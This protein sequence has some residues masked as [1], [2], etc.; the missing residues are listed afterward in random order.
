[1]FELAAFHGTKSRWRTSRQSFQRVRAS[2]APAKGV[3]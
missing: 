2:I 1:V 3:T